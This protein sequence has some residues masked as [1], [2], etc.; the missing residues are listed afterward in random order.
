MLYRY[1]FQKKNRARP[2]IHG[3]SSGIFILGSLLLISASFPIASWQLSNFFSPTNLLSPLSQVN[4]R[5][6]LLRSSVLALETRDYSNPQSWFDGVSYD[7]AE[8]ETNYSLS[9]SKLGIKSAE[10]KIGGLDLSKSLIAWPTSVKPG[11]PGSTIIFGH[12]ALP[13]FYSPASYSTIFTHIFDLQ[14][15][16]RI[17]ISYQGVQYVFEVETKRIVDSTD[18]SVLEQ[19]F[20]ASRLVLVTCVPPGTYLKR[21]VVTAKLISL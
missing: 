1:V 10:V 14:S 11:H 19:H 17:A 21:G 5:I 3:L 15:G 4:S 6:S 13:L 2:R 20:D 7:S 9:I 8:E 16:D 18:L 12:S